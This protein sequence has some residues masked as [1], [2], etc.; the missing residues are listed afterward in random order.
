VRLELP[1]FVSVTLLEL[2]LPALTLPKL[3]L[4][5]VALIV[6]EAATPTPLKATAFGELGALLTMLTL[7]LRVPAVVGAKSALNVVVPPAATVA[8]VFSPLRL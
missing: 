8:G 4:V 2:V 7:P 3:R 5:G 6:T 1:V